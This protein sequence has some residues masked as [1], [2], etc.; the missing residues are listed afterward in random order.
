MTRILVVDDSVVE[1]TLASRLLAEHW[2]VEECASAD[3]ALFSCDM[4]PVDLVVTD[5]CMPERDGLELLRE[6]QQ[7]H[8]LIPVV[9]MTGYGSEEIAVKALQEGAAGYVTKRR[10]TGDLADVTERVLDAAHRSRHRTELLRLITRQSLAFELDNDQRRISPLV[11]YVTDLCLRL[12]IVSEHD[13]VRIAIALEEALLNAIIH[14]N[15]E[16]GS[17]LREECGNTY[18]RLIARRKSHPRYGARRVRVECDLTPE[19]ARIVIRDEGPGFDVSTLP[20]PR[21]PARIALASGRGVLLMRSFLDEVSHN[22]TGNEITLV[23]RRVP[24]QAAPVAAKV[25]AMCGR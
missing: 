6:L 4:V 9:V 24:S 7:R 13:R 1:R 10:L 19:E 5:L 18:V 23:K 11:H 12:G 22:S 16:V 2:D 14:G 21:D 17:E 25:A 15:L 3:E 8:P 20:D